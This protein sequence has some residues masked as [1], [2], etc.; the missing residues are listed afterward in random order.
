MTPKSVSKHMEVFSMRRNSKAIVKTFQQIFDI[1]KQIY[2]LMET[3]KKMMEDVKWGKPEDRHLEGNVKHYDKDSHEFSRK[4][5][6]IPFYLQRPFTSDSK[7]T[8]IKYITVMID[9]EEPCIDFEPVVVGTTLKFGDEAKKTEWANN[10]ELDWDGYWW[11]HWKWK[12]AKERKE[13]NS[14]RRGPWT[15]E[16]CEVNK[17]QEKERSWMPDEVRLNLQSVHTF[18]IPLV[19]VKNQETLKKKSS[20]RCSTSK[21]SGSA[22]GEGRSRP[23]AL[24]TVGSNDDGRGCAADVSEMTCS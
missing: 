4:I 7:R 8:Q 17:I 14:E 12:Q 15:L 9:D 2:L 5:I 19:D 23:G 20:S 10:T 3:A 1:Y 24:D 11:Y 6:R 13:S 18:G 16:K 21:L 22:G